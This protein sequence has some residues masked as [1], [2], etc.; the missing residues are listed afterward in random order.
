MKID[1]DH[2]YHGAALVQIAEDPYFTTIKPLRLR[3]RTSRSSFVVNRNI[4][5]YLKYARKPRGNFKEYW[6]TFFSKNLT[7]LKKLA[8]GGRHVF[9]G[10]ICV[11]GREICCLPLG[12]FMEMV[13]TRRRAIGKSE[14]RYNILVSMPKRAQFRVC[15]T[16]PDA[17]GS[18]LEGGPRL[19]PRQDFPTRLFGSR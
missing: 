8:E 5:V 4:G 7:E 10:L 11:K 9:L 1:D 13:E 6:F 15:M 19:I 14:G 18:V 16:E 12:D 3:G 2:M 17:R